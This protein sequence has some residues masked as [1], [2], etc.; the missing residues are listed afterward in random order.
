M[1]GEVTDMVKVLLQ[2][3]IENLT[4]NMEMVVR[5][6]IEG[7]THT[8]R[9]IADQMNKLKEELQETVDYLSGS[10]QE[11][12]QMTQELVEKTDAKMAPTQNT[13]EHQAYPGTYAVAAQTQVPTV[14]AA[15]VSK[16][17]TSNKQILIQKDPNTT[18]NVLDNLTERDLIMKANTAIDLM[19]IEATDAP[20]SIAFI[21]AKKR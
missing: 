4:T 5:E 19:G 20:T 8:M 16:G 15:V 7:V 12:L 6:A 10:M 11:L 1:A 13:T 2:K 3:H 9:K 18:D 14:H 21:R 17:E